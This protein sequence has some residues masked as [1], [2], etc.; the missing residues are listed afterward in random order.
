MQST[1][2]GSI[3][4]LDYPLLLAFD[5]LNLHINARSVNTGCFW[6]NATLMKL[7]VLGFGGEEYRVR[8]GNFFDPAREK[9]SATLEP[10]ARIDIDNLL[11]QIFVIHSNIEAQAIQDE[12]QILPRAPGVTFQG[13]QSF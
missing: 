9:D 3:N 5:F 12:L 11:P 7:D 6:V 8:I 10:T 1:I 4:P 13:P 2:P